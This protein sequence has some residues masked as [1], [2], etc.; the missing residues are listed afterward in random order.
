M[1]YP[2]LQT[3]KGSANILRMH[4]QMNFLVHG[5]GHLGGQ[6]VFF[7]NRIMFGID[8][9]EILSSFTDDFPLKGTERSIRAGIAEIE[10]EL[11][12]LDLD[13]HRGCP[14]SGHIHTGSS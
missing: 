12:R 6:D 5:D 3:K 13:P 7:G 4:E 11:A 8:T 1:W 14:P 9:K 10:N 2:Q